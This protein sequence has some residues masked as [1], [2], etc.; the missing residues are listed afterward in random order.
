[1]V[2]LIALDEAGEQLGAKMIDVTG[3]EEAALAAAT[4]VKSHAP[5]QQDAKKLFDAALAEA[6][7]SNRRVWV[8]VSQTRCAPCISWSRWL[9]SQKQLLEKD[10]VI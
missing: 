7:K 6:K 9:D 3:K 10:Y 2:L 8:T 5:P 1:M 4:F